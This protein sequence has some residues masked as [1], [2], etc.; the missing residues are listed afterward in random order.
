MA[1]ELVID[2]L[3]KPVRPVEYVTIPFTVKHADGSPLSEAEMEDLM[4]AFEEAIEE[5]AS[6]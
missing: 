4:K 6:E 1:D 5:I 3:F 2:I